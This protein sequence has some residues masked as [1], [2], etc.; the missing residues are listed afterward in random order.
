MHFERVFI[1]AGCRIP[2]SKMKVNGG[3]MRERSVWGLN[4]KSVANM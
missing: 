1:A 3:K 4:A 2:S